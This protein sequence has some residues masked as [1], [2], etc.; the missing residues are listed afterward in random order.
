MADWASLLAGSNVSGHCTEHSMLRHFVAPRTAWANQLLLQGPKSGASKQWIATQGSAAGPLMMQVAAHESLLTHAFGMLGG[1]IRVL[2]FTQPLATHVGVVGVIIGLVITHGL[3]V[4]S[5]LLFALWCFAKFHAT[6]R[7][8][9]EHVAEKLQEVPDNLL[10]S[11]RLMAELGTLLTLVTSAVFWKNPVHSW[12]VVLTISFT[13]SVLVLRQFALEDL[14]SAGMM[15]SPLVLGLFTYLAISRWWTYEVNKWV[16]QV[17]DLELAFCGQAATSAAV[18]PMEGDA[19]SILQRIDNMRKSNKH[20]R[21]VLNLLLGP[22]PDGVHPDEW[23]WRLGRAHS[24]MCRDFSDPAIQKAHIKQG[25][26]VLEPLVTRDPPCGA[27]LLWKGALL[28][29]EMLQVPLK[30]KVPYAFRIRDTM[31]LA[32]KVDPTLGLAHHALG[33][34]CYVGA[35]LNWVERQAVKAF[36]GSMPEMTY[37]DCE[38]HFLRAAD[39]DP[40]NGRN[41]LRLG[42]CYFA[43]KQPGKAKEWLR[44]AVQCPTPH[45]LDVEVQKEAMVLLKKL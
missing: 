34:W 30:A 38:G 23:T 18:E 31:E 9:P 16:Q 40:H 24:D 35:S 25:L 10:A 7:H 13:L 42:Q 41:C 43:M 28:I 8:H 1:Y 15:Y 6:L 39:Q 27:A 2:G 11:V 26:E 29:H 20:T 5:M 37:A 12:L 33:E 4:P 22:R 44:R 17:Q 3:A 32:C 45:P 19:K 36:F 21:E 14:Q